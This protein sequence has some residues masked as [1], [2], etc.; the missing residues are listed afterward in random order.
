VSWRKLARRARSLR[1]GDPDEDFHRVRILAKRARYS[2]EAVASSLGPRAGKQASR[3]AS[4]CADVQDQLG[5]LQ[6]AVVS[7]QMVRHLSEQHPTNGPFNLAL[8]RLLERQE[9]NAREAKQAFLKVW[10][11]LDRSKNVRWLQA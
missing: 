9:S 4:R 1:P 5:Q 11:R 7:A 2:A 6:D 3:F 8:G 10:D